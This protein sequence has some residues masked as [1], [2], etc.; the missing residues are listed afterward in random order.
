MAGGLEDHLVADLADLDIIERSEHDSARELAHIGSSNVTS[1]E[2][3]GSTFGC[4]R[5]LVDGI[6]RI[7][8]H[9]AV[10]VSSLE[11]LDGAGRHG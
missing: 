6:G 7:D 11:R 4:E 3:A 8:L 10:D 1:F 9:P 5:E 2:A